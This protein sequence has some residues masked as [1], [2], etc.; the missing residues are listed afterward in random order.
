MI[1]QYHNKKTENIFSTVTY[2]L[3]EVRHYKY[4]GTTISNTGNFKLNEIDLKKKGL[5]AS[6]MLINCIGYYSKPSTIIRLFQKTVEPILTY[7]CEIAMAYLSNSWNQNK[8]LLFCEK[9]MQKQL[10]HCLL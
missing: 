6:Y 3:D 5:R 1:F 7:N 10:L 2:I 9:Q 4:L 8:L